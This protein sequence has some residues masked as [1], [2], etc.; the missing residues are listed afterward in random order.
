MLRSK[1]VWN[2]PAAV[3]ICAALLW[4]SPGLEC[5][6][7]AAQGFGKTG[8]STPEIPRITQASAGLGGPALPGPA[9]ALPGKPGG[10]SVLSVLPQPPL[11]ASRLLKP[12]PRNSP[13]RKFLEGAS[14]LAPNIAAGSEKAHPLPAVPFSRLQSAGVRRVFARMLEHLAGPSAV[15]GLPSKSPADAIR[16]A[17]EREFSARVGGNPAAGAGLMSGH[18]APAKLGTAR[19]VEL[20]QASVALKSGYQAPQAGVV[21][22]PQYRAQERHRSVLFPVP[23][24]AAALLPWIYPWFSAMSSMPETLSP[25]IGL[26]F[27]TAEVVSLPLL[28]Y[29]A[30]EFVYWARTVL[31]SRVVSDEQFYRALTSKLYRMGLHVSVVS[32]L[33]GHVPGAGAVKPLRVLAPA[34]ARPDFS[35]SPRRWKVLAP[36]WARFLRDA[37]VALSRYVRATF[38]FG[39]SFGNIFLRPEI[40]LLPDWY[41]GWILKHEVRHYF[42]PRPD[43]DWDTSDSRP[44]WMRSAARIL[45]AFTSE[46]SSRFHELWSGWLK[47][48][49][50]SVLERAIQETG[51]YLPASSNFQALLVRPVDDPG[52][53]DWYDP[54]VYA[55]LSRGHAVLEHSKATPSNL[56]EY[57]TSGRGPDGESGSRAAVSAEH[58]NRYRVIVIPSDGLQIPEPGGLEGK[59]LNLGLSKLDPLYQVSQGRRVARADGR[60]ASAFDKELEL[61]VR[62]AQRLRRRGIGPGE[63]AYRKIERALSDMWFNASQT[64]LRNIRLTDTIAAAYQSLDD[65][66]TVFFPWREQDPGLETVRKLLLYWRSEDGGRFSVQRVDLPEGGYVLAARKESNV[67]L[68]FKAQEGTVI[69]SS[70]R[71]VLGNY[72]FSDETRALLEKHGYSGAEIEL[73]RRRRSSAQYAAFLRAGYSK[74]QI[75]LLVEIG[76]RV[77]GVFGKDGGRN[78]LF[79]SVPRNQ[80]TAV[81]KYAERS[82]IRVHRTVGGFQTSLRQSIPLHHFPS[83]LSGGS[84]GEGFRLAVEDTGVYA[85]H[86][87][88]LGRVSYADIARSGSGDPRSQR[89]SLFAT[90]TPSLFSDPQGHGTHVTGIIAANG[91]QHKG[92]APAAHVRV[93][94]VFPGNGE[95]AVDGVLMEGALDAKEWGANQIN[96]S[97]GLMGA[98][99]AELAEWYSWLAQEYGIFIAAAAGNSG[100]FDWTLSQP[101]VGRYVLNVGSVTKE[102]K[103]SFFS[104]VGFARYKNSYLEWMEFGPKGVLVG[105]DVD[106]RHKDPFVRGVESTKSK[107][108]PPSV[109][110]SPSQL[111]TRASGTSQAAPHAAAVAAHAKSAADK[112][113]KLETPAA[114][115]AARAH[116]TAAQ[117][118]Y[119]AN[120]VFSIMMIMMRSAEDLKVPVVFQGAG[121]IDAAATVLLANDTFHQG[122]RLERLLRRAGLKEDAPLTPTHEYLE[123][124]KEV[125]DLQ[126]QVHDQTQEAG[127]A[128]EE[129][130]LN[131]TQA[132]AAAAQRLQE[133]L[134]DPTRNILPRML[135]LLDHPVWLVRMY[136]AFALYNFRAPEAAL[137]LAKYALEDGDGRV[138]Q[139]AALALA[140]VSTQLALNSM[141]DGAQRSA[142]DSVRAADAELREAVANPKRTMD[143][144]MFAAHA[145]AQHGDASGIGVLVEGSRSGVFEERFTAAWL[146][147][148]LG[149]RATPEAAA[150]LADGIRRDPEPVVRHMAAAAVRNV[151]RDNPTAL[152][153][154]SQGAVDVVSSL[155]QASSERDMAFISTAVQVFQQM[156][157]NPKLIAWMRQDEAV[158]GN[159]RKFIDENKDAAASDDPLG[160]MVRTLAQ[161][162][163]VPIE[164]PEMSV[165]PQGVGIPGIDPNMGPIHLL[166]KVPVKRA[167]ALG[168][169]DFRIPGPEKASPA[170]PAR[171]TSETQE[172]W[173]TL[174][175]DPGLMRYHEVELQAVLPASRMLRIGVPDHRVRALLAKLES[176]GFEVHRSLP[177]YPAAS[178]RPGAY[179]PPGAVVFVLGDGTEDGDEPMSEGP[180]SGAQS[181]GASVNRVQ[182]LGV[183]GGTTADVVTGIEYIR[184]AHPDPLRRPAIIEARLQSAEGPDGPLSRALTELALKNYIVVAPRGEEPPPGRSSPTAPAGAPLVQS[185]APELLAAWI[186]E[187]GKTMLARFGGLPDGYGLWLQRFSGRS[188]EEGV[189]AIRDALRSPEKVKVQAAALIGRARKQYGIS[190]PRSEQASRWT[191]PIASVAR[192]LWPGSVIRPF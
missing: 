128:A 26:L 163:N 160:A 188:A 191:G 21:P 119:L 54:A 85:S 34:L 41:L 9:S 153:V 19:P 16:G 77:Y 158:R 152:T 60:E 192:R 76:A 84:T 71:D 93:E 24:T 124:L 138:R 104:S 40:V 172:V 12:W 6:R 49:R 171:R 57:L 146:L 91:P 15:R 36:A 53:A 32:A 45:W 161:I 18:D 11:G 106:G 90:M 145:L 151:A 148:Q 86:P 117:K 111:E 159:I 8:S 139:V 10:L 170:D 180:S 38:S 69:E 22:R 67:F 178:R 118:F 25:L 97:L 149:R 105:G 63:V 82:G 4:T 179:T 136:A 114:R 108:A 129:S 183:N 112:A 156:R 14:F 5:Y 23:W 147:G 99:D 184:N 155:L 125:W 130:G 29:T 59:R 107:D 185:E 7:L 58:R 162:I 55:K 66:G 83:V 134:R 20:R 43:P 122:T 142:L 167:A 177:V 176:M 56:V 131:K 30:V 65:G 121:F 81:Q 51:W 79:V 100:L 68:W 27:M 75:D 140:K 181:T 50:I 78:H 164:L 72:E 33:I 143:A 189:Q 123:G 47:D 37:A 154:V 175:V 96:L 17:G 137:A 28:A 144:R 169:K 150:A 166:V 135:E 98:V 174:G 113:L 120:A 115:E 141:L 39:V 116:G 132:K 94:N 168:F 46:I 61:L 80:V 70:L 2:R 35:W 101:G 73:I 165:N 126:K 157:R 88:F 42:H 109:S 182:V 186:E 133:V 74:E 92:G 103:P 187:L 44:R 48:I 52:F 190:A 87:Y 127:R 95:G 13:L 1:C 64:F 3:G 173:K 102:K 110:D 62:E 89:R 31:T